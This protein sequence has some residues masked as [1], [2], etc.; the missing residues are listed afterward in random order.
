MDWTF[1]QYGLYIVGSVCF[2]AGSVVGLV[3]YLAG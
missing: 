3:R 1:I 2:L